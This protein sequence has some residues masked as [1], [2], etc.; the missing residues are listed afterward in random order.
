MNDEGLDALDAFMLRMKS[1]IGLDTATKQRHKR[2]LLELRGDV[3]RLCRLVEISRP[4]DLDVVST[5]ARAAVGKSEGVAETLSVIP[6]QVALGDAEVPSE[7]V[8][9]PTNPSKSNVRELEIDSNTESKESGASK[10][11]ESTILPTTDYKTS[12]NLASP[13]GS[14]VVD[15]MPS[16]SSSEHASDTRTDEADVSADS[17]TEPVK[18]VTSATSDR[19]DSKAAPEDSEFTINSDA[20]LPSVDQ[21][22]EKSNVDLSCPDTTPLVQSNSDTVELVRFWQ[23][24][25]ITLIKINQKYINSKIYVAVFHYIFRCLY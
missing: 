5:K 25:C 10:S 17:L 16:M 1:G 8:V 15:N 19:S 2:R 14:S 6:E 18:L 23:S 9:E 7:L 24:R 11:A 13:K 22:G 3:V 4:L 21:G 12:S 20:K